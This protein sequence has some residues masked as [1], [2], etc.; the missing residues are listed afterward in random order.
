MKQLNH[1]RIPRYRDYFAIDDRTLWFGMV[2]DYVPGTCLK[3]ALAQG[4]RFSEAEAR[5][6][7]T[8]VLQILRY[9]HNLN[10]PV[11]HR[12][13]KPSNLIWGTDDQV[14]LV[15]FGA[16][17]D[18]AATEGAT[19]TVVGT[20]GYAPLEQFGGRTVPASDLYALG[21]TL[22][23]LLT[24]VAPAD[25]PQ[26]NLQLQFTDRV[27]LTPAF[28]RWLQK[29]TEPAL[30]RRFSQVQEAIAALESGE[31]LASMD[32]FYPMPANTSGQGIRSQAPVPKEILGWNWG[33]FLLTPYWALAHRIWLGIWVLMLNPF[34]WFFTLAIGYGSSGAG[35]ISLLVLAVNLIIMIRLGSYGNRLAWKSLP[36]RNI[37]HFKTHQRRW[38]IAGIF[39]GIPFYLSSLLPTLFFISNIFFRYYN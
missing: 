27:T 25:L 19:F 1:P 35:V 32:T 14:Y 34:L 26:R 13:I 20:Y 4:K 7:A 3:D 15:D 33:A 12:D 39:L 17:Q 8:N 31:T 30:E 5:K 38:A 37:E 9:L 18:R 23:H 28:A 24:G 2:Q 29:L 11:L 16:V 10:P 36:W 21:T 22:I 6:I